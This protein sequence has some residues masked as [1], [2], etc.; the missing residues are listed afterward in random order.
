MKAI[1]SLLVFGCVAALVACS[2]E[3]EPGLILLKAGQHSITLSVDERPDTRVS[4]SHQEGESVYRFFWSRDDAIGV[5][6]PG[7]EV[8]V[9]YTIDEIDGKKASFKLAEDFYIEPGQQMVNIVYP[10]SLGNDFV[11]PGPD[12]QNSFGL[13]NMGQYTVLYAK[14][15]P[16]TDGQFGDVKLKHA[17]S[18][19]HFPAGF[20]FFKGD[21]LEELAG[22]YVTADLFRVYNIFSLLN[23]APAASDY[24]AV[25]LN[26]CIRMTNQGQLE[27]GIYIPFFVPEEGQSIHFR[28]FMLVQVEPGS[29]RSADYLLWPAAKDVMPGMV[30]EAQAQTFPSQD[31]IWEGGADD[32]GYHYEP[33]WD[34]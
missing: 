13:E 11:L 8:P 18:Y 2:K 25:R 24:N 31:L 34:D 9:L 27:N 4:Y 1:K 12:S 28:W 3:K 19:L 26:G 17:T 6:V 32:G 21:G 16:M 15:V 10:F 5:Y 14:D 33:G 20:V 30:Y 23:L 22:V 7:R 29:E